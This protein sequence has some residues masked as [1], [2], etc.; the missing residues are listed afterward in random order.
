MERAR[1]TQ[2][3]PWSPREPL[4]SPAGAPRSHCSA[5]VEGASLLSLPPTP[6]P[7]LPCLHTTPLL[8]LPCVLFDQRWFHSTSSK[9]GHGLLPNASV[10][11]ALSQ[12]LCTR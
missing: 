5:K 9:K 8:S 12:A 4:S 10:C 3:E 1:M 11:Q 7:A 6:F 2:K